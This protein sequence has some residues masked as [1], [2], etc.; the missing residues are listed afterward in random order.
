MPYR[1]IG[2][3]VVLVF[4]LA[5]GAFFDAPVKKEVV[6]QTVD[7]PTYVEKVV[8]NTITVVLNYS[9]QETIVKGVGVFENTSSGEILDIIVGIRPGTGRDLLSIGGTTYGADLQENLAYVRECARNYVREDTD[10]YDITVGIESSAIS[11][12]GLSG[13]AAMCIGAVALLRNESVNQTVVVSGGV[14]SDGSILEIDAAEAKIN[15]AAAAGMSAIILS[16]EQEFNLTDINP[17]IQIIKAADV[18]Q[19]LPYILIPKE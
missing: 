8:N 16:E 18:G 3:F 9:E 5:A 12:R 14:G 6:V 1:F 17:D 13:N 19:A 10:F 2:L 11:I 4:F 7:V 15:A